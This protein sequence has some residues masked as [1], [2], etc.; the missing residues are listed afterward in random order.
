MMSKRDEFPAKIKR[1]LAARAGH[2]CSFPGCARHTSGPS[3][4]AP[5]AS[6]NLGEACHLSAAASGTGA[7]RYDPSMTSEQRRSIDNGIWMCRTHAKLIDSDEATYTVELLREWK[8]EAEARAEERLRGASAAALTASRLYGLPRSPSV[9]FVG[10]GEEISRLRELLLHAEAV[11]I[12]ASVEGLPGIG[13]TELALQ[14]VFQLARDGIFPGGIYWFNAEQPDLVPTWGG[15]IADALEVAPG[16]LEERAAQVL[17]IVS[18]QSGSTLLVLDNVEAWS[19][20]RQPA[21]LPEGTHLRY[22]VTTRRRHL[23]GARFEHVNVGFLDAEHTRQLLARVSGRELVG[24]AGFGDLLEHLGGHALATELAG[25]FL[26]AYDDETPA[27]YL[28]ELRARHKV[29]AEVSEL[30]RYNQTVHQAFQTLWDRLDEEVRVAWRLAACFE[31]ELVTPELSEA[32]GLVRQSR[33]QLRRLHLIDVNAE[34]RWWMHRLTRDFGHRSGTTA[35]VAAAQEAFVKGC[36][37]F[38]QQ[39]ELSDGFRPY[40]TNRIHL[41]RAVDLA[42][43]VLSPTDP[44]VSIFQNNLAT[45]L[46]SAGD[47]PRAKELFG[48]ALASAL[49]NLGEDHPSVA[50]SRSNLALV[51]KALGDLPGARQLLEQALA[52][53]LE[54]LGEDHPSVATSRSNLALVL[55]DLGDLPG[56]RQLLEQAL[57]S[58]LE[59][60]GEDHPSVAT[61]RSNLAGVLQDLGDLPGARQLLEQALASAL[62]NLGEDHPSVATSRSNLAV[63]LQ[64]LG[65]LPGARQLLEQALASALENLGEDHPSV[66]TSRS[67]LALV[68]KALGDLPGARQL[69][70]QALA[71][72]LENLGEDHPS[73]ATRRSN[74]ALVLQALGDLPGARQLLEQALASALENLG[75]D[76]PSVATRRSNLALVLK[77]LGDL[78]GARQLLEQALAS[79]L[80]NLGEDHPSVATSRS[81]L[82]LV[83]KALGDLPG[84]RQLLEQALASAL[85]NLGEDHPSVA[86]SRSNLA[87][88]LQDLGDLPGA[89]Q[90]LEQA[91]ASALENLG[92]DHP[93]VATSRFNLA[94]IC[95][96]EG[97]LEG[98][99]DLFQK[100]LAAEEILLGH[101]HPSLALTRARLA[102]ILHRIGDVESARLAAEKALQVV[103]GQPK[104]SSFRVS[105]EQITAAIL[106]SSAQST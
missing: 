30:V 54:N 10:R 97:D 55:Q 66:A 71:S 105:V 53:A 65:D 104:G 100:A 39:I 76:H 13:K 26:G 43:E 34:G 77:D 87:G 103:S 82:A 91:L 2:V 6:V 47:Y 98:A 42:L 75:E 48:Q 63:V 27:S 72:D 33:R 102:E 90:L 79:D 40:L 12:A 106:G 78:P 36:A 81:N 101:N 15:A 64:A 3:D 60:L 9:K 84:A 70:E 89:R 62:E 94:M 17:R 18:R 24:T 85:E 68:L 86:T 69:L 14:L 51:L 5:E 28:V 80:E 1:A 92:E 95:R 11:R 83:L 29:E 49:E 21:P 7:R 25:A 45:G 50:T 52:S 32:V 46:Q 88:V 67:N 93:S 61:R 23:G 73:V 99:R 56:A 22:L 19:A 41:D 35:E 59:N 31:P 74:L 38:A 8:G 57:A 96:D 58:D 44:Q 20:D 16:P 4:E 37:E